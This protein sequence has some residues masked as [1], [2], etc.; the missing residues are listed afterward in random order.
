MAMA[1]VGADLRE[2]SLEWH[3]PEL[4]P[5]GREASTGRADAAHL[6]RERVRLRGT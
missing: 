3:V 2:R 4:R 5:R 1:R 6:L